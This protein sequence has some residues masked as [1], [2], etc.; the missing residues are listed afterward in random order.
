MILNGEYIYYGDT[1]LIVKRKIQEQKLKPN[2]DASVM[3]QWT[4]SDILL[5][6][7]GWLYCCEE[8]KEAEVINEE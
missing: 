1:L 4:G 3:K 5:K 8:I 2:F 6:K 7:E